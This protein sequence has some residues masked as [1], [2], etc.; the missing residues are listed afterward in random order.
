MHK[1]W[2]RRPAEKDVRPYLVW[3]T[4]STP[5]SQLFAFWDAQSSVPVFWRCGPAEGFGDAI[6][7]VMSAVRAE[8]VRP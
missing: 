8:E 1:I 3:K 5:A 7:G 2:W 4:I 6:K